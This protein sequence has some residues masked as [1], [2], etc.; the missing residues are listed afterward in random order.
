MHHVRV[1]ILVFLTLVGLA[2]PALKAPEGQLTWG[3]HVSL[4]A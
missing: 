4:G 2:T 1:A 3:V